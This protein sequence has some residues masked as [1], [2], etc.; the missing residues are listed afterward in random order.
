MQ[1]IEFEINE[2]ITELE[3][4]DEQSKN[5]NTNLEDLNNKKQQMVCLLVCLYIY[6]C[7]LGLV[8]CKT[9]L[10]KEAKLN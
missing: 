2:T 3:N 10:Q 9:L 8:K 6:V 4:I 5:F 1:E 7:V